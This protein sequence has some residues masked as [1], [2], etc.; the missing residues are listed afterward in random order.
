[1]GTKPHQVH[2]FSVR[3]AVDH[4]EIGLEMAI[5]VVL[6]V[7]SECMVVIPVR[8]LTVVS[9]PGDRFQHGAV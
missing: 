5:P 6:P 4:H 1:M 9:Q 7:A 8:Q 2:I 3:F